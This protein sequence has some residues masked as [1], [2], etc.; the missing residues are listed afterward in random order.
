[1][2]HVIYSSL[3]HPENAIYHALYP[4]FPTPLPRPEDV[5][6]YTHWI[7]W[8]ELKLIFQILHLQNEGPEPQRLCGLSRL[9]GTLAAWH[10][11]SPREQSELWIR[12]LGQRPSCGF[13]AAWIPEVHNSCSS[14]SLSILWGQNLSQDSCKLSMCFPWSPS[15]EGHFR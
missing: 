7:L 11:S 12:S 15:C 1:M 6:A 13:Q 8:V 5:M 10:C 9:P 3:L 14:A 2:Q 4:Y